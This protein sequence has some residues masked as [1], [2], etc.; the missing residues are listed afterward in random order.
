ML[1]SWTGP[2]HGSVY[3]Y[4]EVKIFMLSDKNIQHLVMDALAAEP[5]VD[6]SHIGVAVER[7]VVTLSGHVNSHTEKC[8]VELAAARVRGVKAIAEEVDVRLPSDKKRTD[9]DIARRVIN[10]L[11]WDERVPADQIQ[12]LVEDGV[13]KLHGAVE[14]QYQKEA[15][16]EDVKHLTGVVD[17]ANDISVVSK[18][19]PIAV[20]QKIVEAFR[21]MADLDAQHIEIEADGRHVT[22]RGRVNGHYERELAERAA[23]MVPG[24]CEVNNYINV[25]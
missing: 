13:V 10:I 5:A 2:E 9:D 1:V 3:S 7:G 21:R 6:A 14:W 23:W 11:T 18:V 15:A 20:R 19:E 12:I 25:D 16:E 22:L 24:I 4:S 17:V 8:I